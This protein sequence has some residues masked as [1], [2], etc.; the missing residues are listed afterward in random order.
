MKG[1]G[2]RVE[3]EVCRV[4]GVG[5]TGELEELHAAQRDRVV[6]LVFRLSLITLIVFDALVEQ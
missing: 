3:G 1:L 6:D 2:C 4:E 5:C